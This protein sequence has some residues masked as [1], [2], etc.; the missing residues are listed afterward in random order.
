M[1][2]HSPR[3]F[4]IGPL[5]K[6]RNQL[7]IISLAASFISVTTQTATVDQDDSKPDE[8]ALTSIVNVF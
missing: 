4:K 5:L 7:F 3:S 1:I 6:C 8:P 2:E